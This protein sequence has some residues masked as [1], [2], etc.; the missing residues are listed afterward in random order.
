MSVRSL[1]RAWNEFFFEPRSPTPIC[2]FRVLYGLLALATLILLR[3]D[4]MTWFGT[5]GLYTLETMQKFEPGTRINL[6]VFMPN[7]LWIQGFFWFAVMSAVFVTIGFATRAS[8][9][10][11]F[12]CLVSI[13]QRALFSMH[14]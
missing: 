5:R 13:D 2:L 14:S 12:V 6:F 4:W 8:S 1:I 10:A 7:D 3:P 9:V 11:L